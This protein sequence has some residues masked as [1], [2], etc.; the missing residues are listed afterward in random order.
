VTIESGETAPFRHPMFQT[1]AGYAAEFIFCTFF[2]VAQCI[3][4]F[5][6]WQSTEIRFINFLYPAVCDFFENIVL[7]FGLTYVF[8]SLVTISR[9]FSIPVTAL[10]CKILIRKAFNVSMISAIA[11]I[12]IGFIV[13]GLAQSLMAGEV[14]E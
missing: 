9:S 11:L 7:V 8:P 4:R 1:V 2:Y 5:N 12:S 6:S 3:F 14:I 13:T 10:L